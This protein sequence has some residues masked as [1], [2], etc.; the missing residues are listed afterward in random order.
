MRLMVAVLLSMFLAG[1]AAAQP[2]VVSR[3]VVFDH[4]TIRSTEIALPVEAL[5]RTPLVFVHGWGG[6]RGLFADP[7]AE[8]AGERRMLAIDMPGHGESEDVDGSHSMDLYA[9]VIAAAMDEAG[10]ERAVLIGHSNGASAIRQFARR[11][12]ER[13]AALVVVDGAMTNQIPPETLA[14]VLQRLESDEYMDLVQAVVG[15]ATQRM[16]DAEDAQ[17][18]RDAAFFTPQEVLSR[19]MRAMGDPSI[20]EAD[21]VEPPLL[22]IL[23]AQPAWDEAYFAEVNAIAPRAETHVWE[24]AS[25]YLF[26]D[27][28]ERFARVVRAFLGDRGL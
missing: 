14:A 9:D 3:S 2:E 24:G 25:H 11:Y 27:D 6:S 28:P 21:A 18:V 10:I 20:W 5:A 26:M 19:S 22:L 16:R 15:G 4:A 17:A 7:M 13:V 8:F 1:A 23:A 12:G